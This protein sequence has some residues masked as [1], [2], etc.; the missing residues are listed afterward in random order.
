MKQWVVCEKNPSLQQAIAKTCN[1]S[2]LTAQ[3]LINRGLKTAAEVETFLNPKLKDLPNPFLLP[4]MD[5]AVRRIVQAIVKK[6]NIAIYGDY[7]VDGITSTALLSTFFKEVGVAVRAHIP[8]RIKEGYGLQ[9]A[10]LEKLKREGIDLVI[11]ADCGTKSHAALARA[12]EIGLDVIVTDHHEWDGKPLPAFAF[13]N[14]HAQKVPGG[15]KKVPGTF[16]VELAGCGVAFFLIIA[17]RQRLREEKFFTIGE[18]NLKQYLD[19]VALATVADLAPLTGLNRILVSL[20]LKELKETKK[21]G[22]I[23][24][25]E[26]AGLKEDKALVSS[27]IGFR[28]GPRINAGGRIAKGSLGLDLLCC[29]D[30]ERAKNL[31]K[32]LDQ[33]NQERQSLQEKHLAEALKQAEEKKSNKGLVVF[34]PEWH[35]GIIGLVASRLTEAFYRPTIAFC[36]E[37]EFARGSARSIPGINIVEVLEKCS[38]F[39]E[40]FGGHAQAAGLTLRWDRLKKFEAHLENLLSQQIQSDLFSPTLSIDAEISLSEINPKLLNEL[41]SLRPFG[42]GNPEPVFASAAIDLKNP[43]V[44]G[45]NHLRLTLLQNGTGLAAIGFN[46]KAKLPLTSAKAQAA[47]VPEWNEY[48]G[49]K[50]IQLKIKD[51]KP[52]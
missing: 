40:Q 28:L 18:P 41:E 39:L 3:V 38:E 16:W 2:P 11:S 51:L 29:E 15:N 20:G 43:R 10:V 26:A 47:F 17:L 49:E 9:A 50:T 13:V 46:F 27:D 22:L 4:D 12:K 21:P 45:R 42:I 52:S 1:L 5:K 31:A 32:I 44:V 7:D 34:S 33:C 25:K 8:D 6:E 14:P 37:G 30:L 48:Q 36:L 23:A 24:L 35:P 19:L